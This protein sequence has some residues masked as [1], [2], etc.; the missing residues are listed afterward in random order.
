MAR[1]KK[2]EGWFDLFFWVFSLV[3]KVSA[4]LGERPP[5]RDSLS[6]PANE[7][8]DRAAQALP[9][10]AEA[11]FRRTRPSPKRCANFGDEGQNG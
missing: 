1:R 6:L 5:P 11:E 7:D 3:P 8:L 2:D 10:A 4:A 9:P